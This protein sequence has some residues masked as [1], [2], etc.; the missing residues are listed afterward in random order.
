[1]SLNEIINVNKTEPS[2][3][4]SSKEKFMLPLIPIVKVKE[5]HP[6]LKLSEGGFFV[7]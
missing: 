6:R 4:D 3:S 2:V 1:M 5:I 7:I